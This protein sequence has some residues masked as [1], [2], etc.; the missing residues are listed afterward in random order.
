MSAKESM[1]H[2]LGQYLREKREKRGMTQTEVATSL[3]VRPQFVSNWERGLSSPPWRLMRR[4]VTLYSIPR[5]EMV[6]VMVKE[7]EAFVKNSL[8]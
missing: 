3:K 2:N 4:L 8:K 1:F 5:A 6:R 7:Y